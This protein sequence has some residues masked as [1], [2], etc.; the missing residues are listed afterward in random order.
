MLACLS[1]NVFVGALSARQGAFEPTCT[2]LATLLLVS[3]QETESKE[4]LE[5]AR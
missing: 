2:P 1:H 5:E 3:Q 4:V